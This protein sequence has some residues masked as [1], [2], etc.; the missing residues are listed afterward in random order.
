MRLKIYVAGA[1]TERHVRA[2]MW[3]ARLRAS[4]IEVTHDWPV[5]CDAQTKPDWELTAEARA[6]FATED[7]AGVEAADAVWLLIPATVSCGAWIELGYALAGRK[8]VG[9]PRA[10]IVSGNWKQ[11]IFAELATERFESDEAAFAY[12]KSFAEG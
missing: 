12:L 4:N 10:V 8:Y 7:L 5:V 1:Y 3:I 6:R 9:R 11:S 2:G